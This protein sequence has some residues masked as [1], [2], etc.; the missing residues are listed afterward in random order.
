MTKKVYTTARGKPVDM[1]TL[2][3][4]NEKVRAVGNMGVN[5]RG[6]RIDAQGNV[7]DSK[8]QQL[9]RRIQRQ[10]NVSNDPVQTNIGATEYEMP[11]ADPVEEIVGLTP[12]PTPIVPADDPIVTPVTT[13][14]PLSDINAPP[15]TKGLAGAMA[16]SKA[17]KD[18]K[19][20][21][22]EDPL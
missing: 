20:L 11:V 8:G 22:D 13:T 7:I 3:L 4:Q 19:D 18:P 9:D 2:R 21:E 17:A 1:G 12:A 6:D 5:A 16:R 15:K 14:A 10:S